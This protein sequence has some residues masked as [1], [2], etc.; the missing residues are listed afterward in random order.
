[1]FR[2]RT[3]KVNRGC[4]WSGAVGLALAAMIRL[5]AGGGAALAQS[6]SDFER[7]MK[8][9]AS[10]ETD[11]VV[12]AV[13]ASD[14][15]FNFF[16]ALGSSTLS[17]Y[18]ISGLRNLWAI[19]PGGQFTP[20]RMLISDSTDIA[21]LTE[22]PDA[23]VVRYFDTASGIARAN[24]RFSKETFSAARLLPDSLL[25]GDKSGNLQRVSL[26]AGEIAWKIAIEG[27]DLGRTING[28]AY[29][30]VG[31]RQDIPIIDLKSGE[32]VLRLPKDRV[33]RVLDFV[34]SQTFLAAGSKGEILAFEIGNEKPRWSYKTGGMA[35]SAVGAG[36]AVLVGSTDNFIYRLNLRRGSVEWKARLTDRVLTAPVV[37]GGV[38]FVANELRNTVEIRDLSDGRIINR[39]EVTDAH[40]IVAIQSGGTSG[41]ILIVTA[42]HIYE[43]AADCRG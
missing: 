12:S 28:G 8:A 32:V 6:P 1:M 39:F 5:T 38:F 16:T 7:P 3:R 25:L 33:E 29:V 10:V 35:T 27:L 40:R 2:S 24:L 18:S 15:E 30:S 34:E 11:G 13:S 23:F 9:C 37:A 21:V 20:G 42:G 31:S 43:V 41:T 4:R 26:P 36:D 14:N 22:T 17:K 19:E